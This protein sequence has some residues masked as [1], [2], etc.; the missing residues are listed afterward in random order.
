MASKVIEVIDDEEDLT[1]VVRDLI[2][3]T[4]KDVR[5]FISNECC[6]LDA[7]PDLLIIDY[8]M[9]RKTGFQQIKC[10]AERKCFPKII[11]WTAWCGE[12]VKE[13]DAVR[14]INPNVVIIQKPGYTELKNA[15]K[16]LLEQPSLISICEN[17]QNPIYWIDKI[18]PDV[19]ICEG[20]VDK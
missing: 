12:V 8:L 2:T 16:Y 15:I 6:S 9:P 14:K 10:C 3:N 1:I 17:C 4:F 19:K 11:V 20:C 13:L 18:D 5:V 7:A